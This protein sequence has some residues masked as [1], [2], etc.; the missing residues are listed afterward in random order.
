MAQQRIFNLLK[1]VQPPPTIWDKIYNWILGRARIIILITELFIAVAFVGKVVEDTIAKNK[2]KQ[3]ESARTEL[4]FFTNSKEPQFRDIQKK[5]TQYN[6]LWTNASNEY[7]ILKE[8]Y[9]I[10]PN[11]GAEI[12]VRIDDNRLTISGFDDLAFVK[13]IEQSLKESK[14]FTAVAVNNLNISQQESSQDQGKF[15][16]VATIVKPDRPM[17]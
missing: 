5:E 4:S 7:D 2:D 13:T 14:S 3:I 15:I 9:S 10:I 6:L 16:L 1:P 8:V 11:A 12:T 17:Y